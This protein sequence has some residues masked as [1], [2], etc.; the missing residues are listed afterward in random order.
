VRSALPSPVSVGAGCAQYGLPNDVW[1][2]VDGLSSAHVYL[3]LPAGY[4]FQNIPE[5]TLL[6]RA[7][8]ARSY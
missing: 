2:H 5:R 8:A 6:G 7:P 4:T 1:F 3:R